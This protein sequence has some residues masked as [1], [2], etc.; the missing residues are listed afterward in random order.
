M[1][2]S[3]QA[4]EPRGRAAGPRWSARP[5]VGLLDDPVRGPELALLPALILDLSERDG[6]LAPDAIDGARNRDVGLAVKV[7]LVLGVD[8]RRGTASCLS[9]GSGALSRNLISSPTDRSPTESTRPVLTAMGPG[10]GGVT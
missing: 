7:S 6:P 3:R 8:A 9:P 10:G 1:T 4:R 2:R 5:R